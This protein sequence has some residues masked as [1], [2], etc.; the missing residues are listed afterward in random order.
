MKA[1]N[2]TLGRMDLARLY[3]PHICAKSAWRKLKDL[4]EDDPELRPLLYTGRRT[5]MPNELERIFA[6]LGKPK[7]LVFTQ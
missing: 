5:F 1:N 2:P 4:M 3:F 6:A 7:Q